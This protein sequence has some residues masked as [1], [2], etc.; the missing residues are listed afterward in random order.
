[1]LLFDTIRA[2][3]LKVL[4]AEL[5]HEKEG[6]EL[7]RGREAQHERRSVTANRRSLKAHLSKRMSGS[8]SGRRGFVASLPKSRS[9]KDAE[10][11]SPATPRS[12]RSPS[13]GSPPRSPAAPDNLAPRDVREKDT[14]G[15]KKKQAAED[16]EL[17]REA[18]E[19]LEE[20]HMDISRKWDRGMCRL[21][22]T[23]PAPMREPL[24]SVP[25]PPSQRSPCL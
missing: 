25:E 22:S 3:N 14:E 20:E 12:P 17:E 7:E 24:A 13:P 1:V 19:R 8:G 5:M 4:R 18:K 16:K 23:L 15:D 10:P 6:H 11:S 2:L 21:R 9:W